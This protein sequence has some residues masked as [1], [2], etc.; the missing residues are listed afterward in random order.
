MPAEIIVALDTSKRE[1]ALD[2]VD[3]LS[4]VGAR[5]FKV[6]LQL[7][8]APGCGRYLVEALVD[9]GLRVFLDLKFFDIPNT[10][11]AAAREVRSMKGVWGFTVHS[12]GGEAVLDAAVRGARG[13]TPF[14]ESMPDDAPGRPLVFAVTTLSSESRVSNT[15]FLA[16]IS[17]K[18]NVD[19]IVVPGDEV[20]SCK[21]RFPSLLCIVPGVRP[22]GMSGAFSDDQVRIV[23]PAEAS[24]RGA[25]YIVV[26]RPITASRDP[27][28]AF[29]QVRDQIDE[30]R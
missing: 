13:A 5:W 27:A 26:G 10:V 28:A 30:G 25:D 20:C 9:R 18:R 16:E 1:R 6:G 12:A 17:A 14:E 4:S 8:L 7:F 22:K 24:E 29:G 15:S 19:G 23:T 2:I 11:N 21:S 3:S